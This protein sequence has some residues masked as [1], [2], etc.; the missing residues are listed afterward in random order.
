MAYTVKQARRLADKS[1][2]EMALLLGVSRWTY[3]KIESHP[4]NA[5][6]GQARKISE[7][8]GVPLDDIIFAED[9]TFRRDRRE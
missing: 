8:T 2:A 7:I 3:R 1:Q 6:I 9:S 4:E 5:K